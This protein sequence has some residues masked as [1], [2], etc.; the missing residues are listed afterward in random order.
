MD[1]FF[2]MERGGASCR[3]AD[4]GLLCRD[5]GSARRFYGLDEGRGA[6]GLPGEWREERV[7][8]LL[9]TGAGEPV[10]FLY[11]ASYPDDPLRRGL[12]KSCR[13]RYSG[14]VYLLFSCPGSP[15]PAPTKST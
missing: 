12:E 10:Y 4:G 9:G 11:N 15:A 2:R 13:V 8:A 6:Q 7:R 1:G 14:D 3:G 5:V